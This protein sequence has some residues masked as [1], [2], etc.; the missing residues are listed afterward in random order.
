VRSRALGF[1]KLAVPLVCLPMIIPA[2][3]ATRIWKDERSVW[4]AAVERSPN[5]TRALAALSRVERQAG[6]SALAETLVA[7]ALALDPTY[8]P[9]LVTRIYNE[10][11]AGDVERARAHLAELP[12]LGA[13][14]AK[15]AKKARRCAAL[16]AAA[17]RACVGN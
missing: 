4:T 17:A 3:Q 1:S 9:A 12:A 6:N 7:Q 14:D 5:S 16:D 13:D 15:G 11:H 2:Y 8:A 10:L